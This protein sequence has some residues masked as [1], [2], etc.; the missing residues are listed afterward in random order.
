MQYNFIISYRNRKEHLDEFIR[1]FTDYLKN[2][3]IDVQ[4]YIIHQITPGDFNRGALNNIGFMEVCKIRPDGLFVFHDVDTYP[5]YWG[6]I[7]YEAQR[8]EFKRPVK[9]SD[10]ENLGL[11]CSCWKEEYEKTN[12]FANFWGWGSEDGALYFRAKKAGIPI[13]ENNMIDYKD[14]RY[15]INIEHYRSVSKQHEHAAKNGN[16]LLHEK[17]TGNSSNGLSAI[18]Y[19][20][21]SSVELAPRFTVLNVDFLLKPANIQNGH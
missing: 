19:K 11:I 14:T 4:F 2:K 16:L 7:P 12:G 6:S 8:G 3:E 15:V 10:S 13:N 1:R 17:Q 5:T 18:E 21:L 9:N 20:V